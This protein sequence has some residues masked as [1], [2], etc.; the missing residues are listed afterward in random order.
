MMI[1]S[2]LISKVLDE[3]NFHELVKSNVTDSDFSDLKDVYKFVK[4]YVRE[5]GDTPDYRTVVAEFEHFDYFPEVHD[6]FAYLCKQLKAQKIKLEAANVLQTEVGT[7][8][9]K[10]NGIEFADW[11]YGEAQRLKNIAGASSFLGT[12]FATNG[13]ERLQ[14]YEDAKEERTYTYIPTPYP[15]LTKGLGGGFEL[16]DYIL[17]SAYT[18]RGKSW[19][20]SQIATVAWQNDFGVLYYS[21]ELTKE[22]QEFRFDTVIGHFDN[23]KVRRGTL[24]NEEE[25]REYL[26]GFNEKNEVPFIIK[27]MEDLP[28]GLSIDVIE[29]DLI[30]M[31]N[32]GLVVIDGFNLMNHGK[33]GRDA[34]GQTSR[35][36]R[37]LFGRYK[38]AG[39]VVHQTPTSAEKE[40]M[41]ADDEVGVRQPVPPRLDQYSE[42]V[43]T[44]QDPATI[45]TFDQHDGVGKLMIAKAR[46]PVVGQILDL[47]CNFN[48][49]YITEA[50]PVDNF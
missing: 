48:Y 15:T 7:K 10:L 2:Q 34:M 13:A 6:S 47:R 19:I 3:K 39:L 27:T 37:Q 44:I 46:E 11:L 36:L 40:N 49:G 21:P 25:Y 43:A 24:E 45:L 50:T 5:Y 29:A 20:A 18:N 9:N 30:S 31:D 23:V 33:G 42:T 26:D 12:N 1:E 32:I 8:Y 14:K 17:V 28:K 35:K 16:G 38:V 22:Q 4:D 41:N